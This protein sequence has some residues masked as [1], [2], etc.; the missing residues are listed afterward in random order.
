M[1]H[2]VLLLSVLVLSSGCG[3]AGAATIQSRMVQYG[4]AAR[5]RMVP[6]FA[7]AGVVYPPK[8]VTF[9]GLKEEKRLEVYVPGTGTVWRFVKSYPIRAAS[10]GTG[11]KLREG[12]GQVPEGFYAIESLNPNSSYHLSLRVN[13]PNAEDRR[14]AAAEGR[15]NLGGDIMIHGK[16]CSVGCLAMGDPASEEMFVLAADVGVS[17]I[18]V[19]LCPVDFRT[20]PAFVPSAG[21]PAWLAPL[22]ARLK[23]ELVK[24]PRAST[25]SDAFVTGKD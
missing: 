22:Y 14:N 9:V 10:G 11:P 7:K 25:R 1:R 15:T 24:C 17:R 13:Y 18:R 16:N 19:L 3:R 21:S 6:D 2:L 20:N 5:A 4:A 23:A 12:D 8:A